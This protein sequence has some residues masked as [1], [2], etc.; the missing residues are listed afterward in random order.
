MPRVA[1][2]RGERASGGGDLRVGVRPRAVAVVVNDER[3]VDRREIVEEVD[4]RAPRHPLNYHGKPMSLPPV[5]AASA[6]YDNLL[7]AALRQFFGR[8]TFE[9]E[10]IP[11][12]SSDGR[13]AIEPTNDPSVLSIRWFGVAARAARAGA[14]AVHRARS[15]AGA[16]DRDGA[17]GALSRD[18]RSEADA[19][20]RRA[21]PRRDRGSL[22]RRVP[23][24][25]VARRADADARRP[26]GDGDRGAPRR[27]ALELREPRDLVGRAAARGER[28][29]RSA[30]VR[31]PR[32]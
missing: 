6:L 23:V 17:R 16:R 31:L 13:L 2:P 11:S 22:H 7:Q 20:A 1:Q 15:A 28:P 10:P 3:A 27:G 18:L 14:A 19:G 5:F 29:I 4:E 8:A 26:R 21:V 12:L 24:D 30:P 25:T 9:T 32:A